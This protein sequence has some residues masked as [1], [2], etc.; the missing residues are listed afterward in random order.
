MGAAQTGKM[1]DAPAKAARTALADEAFVRGFGSYG[2]EEHVSYMLSTEAFAK[3]GGEEWAKWSTSIRTR[4]AD[5]PA[6]GRNLAG[7]PLHH[8]HL[9][10]H[11]GLADHAGHPADTD[12]SR[13]LGRRLSD[14]RQPG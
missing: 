12:S 11:R 2:G 5:H 4:L 1:A 10:L 9:V 8:Q 7:R 14:A 13:P 6:R 3:G